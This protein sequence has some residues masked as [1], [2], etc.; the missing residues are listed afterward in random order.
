[1]RPHSAAG[2]ARYRIATDI[3]EGRFLEGDRLPSVRALASKMQLNPLT[4]AKAY[5]GFIEDYLIRVERGV[6]LFVADGG[7]SKLRLSEKARFL[8]EDWPQIR[9]HIERLGLGYE[10]LIREHL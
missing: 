10:A 9:A 7:P 6:G 4:I 8:T 3:L 1:M 2:T 5:Q